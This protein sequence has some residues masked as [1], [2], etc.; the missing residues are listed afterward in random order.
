MKKKSY[1]FKPGV[2]IVNKETGDI[3]RVARINV[4][5]D[6][7]LLHQEGTRTLKAVDKD[8]LEEEYRVYTVADNWLNL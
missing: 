5:Q 7:Y 1:L 6:E 3:E 8:T 2:K 4:T